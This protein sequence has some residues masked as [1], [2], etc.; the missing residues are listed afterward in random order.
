MATKDKTIKV[1]CCDFCD[2]TE[3]NKYQQINTCS[4]C[5]KDFCPNC[6]EVL[7]TE[8]GNVDVEG[9]DGSLYVC[10]N[11]LKDIFSK[12]NRRENAQRS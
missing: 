4:I 7:T 9:Y 5:G 11:C 2:E 1:R 10:K 6:G 3:E 8:S 12:R